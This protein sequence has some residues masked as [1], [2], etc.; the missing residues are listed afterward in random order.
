M[1]DIEVDK[2]GFFVEGWVVVEAH[3]PVAQGL[4]GSLTVSR[5]L[6]RN[7][8][9]VK[10]ILKLRDLEISLLVL[11]AMQDVNRVLILWVVCQS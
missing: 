7:L 8:N 9:R 3:Q 10:S 11:T 6:P 5:I 1:L 2:V 4:G